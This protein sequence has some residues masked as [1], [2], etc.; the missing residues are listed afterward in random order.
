MAN[1]T[2]CSVN[3]KIQFPLFIKDGQL[4]HTSQNSGPQLSFTDYAINNTFSV[5]RIKEKTGA[6][7]DE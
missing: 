1:V 3:G 6:C 5:N 4:K 2:D 7:R